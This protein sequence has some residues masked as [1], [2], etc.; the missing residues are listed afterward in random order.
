MA[1]AFST[2]WNAHRSTDPKQLLF[3]IS[4]LGFEEL[5]L[6][7]NLESSAVR[8]IASLA[9]RMGIRIISLHNFCP[10]PDG[11]SRQ[12]AL[13]DY[14]SMSSLDEE[15]RSRS[16]RH[17]KATINT[18]YMLGAK[19]VVLH[20]GRVEVK[21]RTRQLLG[22]YNKGLKESARFKHLKRDIL[23]ERKCL[24]A[25][26]LS[27]TLRSLE[28]L[29]DYAAK[30]KILL[31]IETRFYCREIPAFE[32]IGVI[33]KHFRG[34]QIYYWHDTGHAQLMDMLGLAKHK[35]FL[36]NYGGQMLGVH[37]QDISA[38]GRDHL[39]PFKG[40]FD[41]KLLKPYV[42]EDTL[43]VIEA[44]APAQA[45][46]LIKSKELLESIFNAAGKNT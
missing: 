38:G 43:K 37:L 11:L 22:L 17:T 30:R 28:E 21:D 35:D 3:E 5:E 20:C 27:N 25:P 4:R 16:L 24:Y 29:N 18:A 6:S 15:E 45:D 36:D 8:E 33:L 41:F 12:I 1:L 19:A 42:K 14:Y 13:P 23:H 10:I 40:V 2:S 7:F 32:E 39:A 9:P 44:H 31:G 26:F 34:S 46:E